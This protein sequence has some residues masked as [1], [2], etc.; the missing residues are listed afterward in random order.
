MPRLLS[1]LGMLVCLASCGGGSSDSTGPSTGTVVG[2]IRS[3]LGPG[4]SAVRVTVA[5][6]SGAVLASVQSA[7]DG[8]YA[9][10]NV[11]AGDGTVSID[12]I[13][14]GCS[15]PTPSGYSGLTGG[16]RVTVNVTVSCN[17]PTGTIVGTVTSSLGGPVSGA[18]IAVTPTGL[19]TLST[20]TTSS[21]GS[22]TV[23][24]VPV[25]NGTGTV[26]TSGVPPGCTAPAAATYTSFKPRDTLTVNSVVACNAPV[27]TIVVSP[28]NSTLLPGGQVQLSAA[29]ADSRG[30]VLTG[31]IV[32][33]TSDQANV[34]TIQQTGL[35]TAVASGT[36]HI[37]ATSESKTAVAVIT[38][39]TPAISPFLSKPLA[40]D[41]LIY[42]FMDHDVPREFIDHNG[43]RITSWGESAVTVDGHSGYDWPATIGT[44]VLAA[45]DGVV[46]EAGLSAPFY[47][48]PLAK[49]VTQL[50]V[51]LQHIASSGD[52]FL[53]YYAHLSETNVTVGQH[54]STG[55]QVGLSGNSGCSTLPHLHFEVDRLTHTN[56]G[57]LAAVD[58]FGWTGSQPDPWSIDPAGA[59]SVYLWKPGQAP[60]QFI[61]FAAPLNVV[62]V[63]I[64]LHPQ[65]VAIAVMRW[66]G[67]HDESNPNNEYVTLQIDP[68]VY[69][70]ASYDMTGMSLRN[71]EG[72]V[73]HFP[74]GFHIAA[75]TPV[76]LH[77][78]SGGDTSTDL[79]WGMS[80]G[81]FDNLGDCA[82]LIYPDGS[83]Y[84]I[85][86]Y[87]SCR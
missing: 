73:Y 8:S 56:N 87:V 78:G 65:P 54:V 32:T 9:V 15:A 55:Q 62:G 34:V 6:L 69:S 84:L 12:G 49:T 60:N 35:A 61:G 42:N 2:T 26:A 58:P 83:Y 52:V 68:S 53:T 27:A 17:A 18:T 24:N 1:T 3:S 57:N 81:V 85:G 48:P 76:N 23:S 44:P 74:T 43:I 33:W 11:S 71:N 75:G 64:P 19:A 46:Y 21:L 25:G 72:D 10:T 79:Y 7:T 38:V 66:M 50:G 67:P 20:V 47:C 63:N 28:A 16:S 14:E 37:T 82:E 31:R 45:G 29:L 22:Y 51:V 41:T 36:A 86:Y 70:G 77:V 40:V 30:N 39:L 4:L 13:P 59:T 80:R 5:P